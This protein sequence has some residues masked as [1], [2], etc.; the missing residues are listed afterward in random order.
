MKYLS[1]HILTLFLHV[2]AYIRAITV[3]E[4]GKSFQGQYLQKIRLSSFAETVFE[5]V[6][7]SQS[8]Y[9]KPCNMLKNPFNQLF[10]Q[11]NL[12]GISFL[13]FATCELFASFS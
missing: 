6:Q 10:D 2:I 9:P 3:R 1:L 5:I 11:V 8:V 13:N 12:F 4:S 7:I